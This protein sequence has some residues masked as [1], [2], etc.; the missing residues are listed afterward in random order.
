MRRAFLSGLLA[1]WLL[2]TVGNY[3]F[4]RD[5]DWYSGPIPARNGPRR[6]R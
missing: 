4:A 3:L 6:R 5:S 1:G 2:N